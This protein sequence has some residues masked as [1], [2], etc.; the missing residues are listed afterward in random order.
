MELEV[1]EDAKGDTA[2]SMD[3]P[4]SPTHRPDYEAYRRENTGSRH[5]GRSRTPDAYRKF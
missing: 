5:I 1:K 4:M 2:E 3:S